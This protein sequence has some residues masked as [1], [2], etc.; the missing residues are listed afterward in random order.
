MPKDKEDSIRAGH[1]IEALPYILSYRN[2]TLVIKL[3]GHAM[4]TG[5]L[6]DNFAKDVTLLR[7]LGLKPVVVHGGGPQISDM[8]ER[9]HIGSRFVDG[10]RYT[11]PATMEVVEMVLCG[12]IGKDI[13]S[14]ITLAGGSAVGL[15][16]K[17]SLLIV[18]ERETLPADGKGPDAQPLDIGLVGRPVSVNTDLLGL[19][20]EGGFIPVISP[21][22]VGADGQGYNINADTAAAAVAVALK[23]RKLVLLTDVEGVLGPDGTLILS[24]GKGEIADM[25]ER[26][27]I[28]GG[29]IPKLECC[30]HAL[31]N[32]C[33]AASVIDGRE[34]HSIL[35]EIFTH[36]GCGTEVFLA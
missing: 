1:L 20:T 7:L 31:E 22:G 10:L 30:V 21:V 13:V 6:L 18:A 4:A 33:E 19:L 32:G 15:S 25:R 3:G 24:L 28:Q 36:R 23:A 5:P 11:D 8:L 12:R 34:P 2:A 16:G 29:M 9:L 27:L 17:D 26:G 14:R 35:L